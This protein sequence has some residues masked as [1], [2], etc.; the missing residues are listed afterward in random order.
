MFDQSFMNAAELKAQIVRRKKQHR[1]NQ[2][3][4]Q[5]IK[6]KQSAIRKEVLLLIAEN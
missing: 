5:Q 4:L 3:Q 1:W 2:H 6:Q